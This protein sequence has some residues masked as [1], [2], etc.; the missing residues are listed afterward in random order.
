MDML[1]LVE[2]AD[3]LSQSDKMLEEKLSKINSGVERFE[4][5]TQNAQ[6]LSIKELALTGTDLIAAGVK[7]GP[8]MGEILK[9]MLDK[10]LDEP[11]SKYKRKLIG[12]FK[13]N[14]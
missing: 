14:G 13:D 5:I 8:N 7:P 6:P 2:Y 11:G 3:V 4:F 9:K 1:F 10:V 12:I